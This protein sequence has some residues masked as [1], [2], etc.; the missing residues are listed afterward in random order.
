MERGKCILSRGKNVQK[1]RVGIWETIDKQQFVGVC[2]SLGSRTGQRKK[3]SRRLSIV[4]T[5]KYPVF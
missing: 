4:E 1:H 2:C 5:L 3:G